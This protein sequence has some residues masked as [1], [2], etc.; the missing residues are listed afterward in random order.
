L[1]VGI[2]PKLPDPRHAKKQGHRMPN[3]FYLRHREAPV[4]ESATRN[5]D[6]NRGTIGRE[7]FVSLLWRY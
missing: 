4:A 6:P 5:R 1:H 2:G 3:L 7:Q